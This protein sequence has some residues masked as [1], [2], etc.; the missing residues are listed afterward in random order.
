MVLLNY[1]TFFFFFFKAGAWRFYMYRRIVEIH[2]FYSTHSCLRKARKLLSS[3]GVVYQR[4]LMVNY[5]NNSYISTCITLLVSQSRYLPS[6]L[7]QATHRDRTNV[8]IDI[9]LRLYRS[10]LLALA[11]KKKRNQVSRERACAL[12]GWLRPDMPPLF[13]HNCCTTNETNSWRFHITTL[14]DFIACASSFFIFIIYFL[15]CR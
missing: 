6:A 14:Y 1:P 15:P 9:T 5:T 8:N 10:C 11:E 2:E 13:L 3:S 4:L 12:Q 7:I